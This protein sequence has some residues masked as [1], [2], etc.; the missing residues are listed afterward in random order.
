MGP[1]GPL[2]GPLELMFLCSILKNILF[3]VTCPFW[4]SLLFPFF[5]HHVVRPSYPSSF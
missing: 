3:G 1:Q 4:L 2:H 5:C